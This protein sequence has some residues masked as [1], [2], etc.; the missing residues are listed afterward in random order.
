MRLKLFAPLAAVLL[1]A[2]CADDPKPAASTGGA[3]ATSAAPAPAASG[4]RPGS[5]ED[6]AVNAGDRVFF[7]FNQYSLKPDA[8]RTLQRQAAWMQR[9]ANV[10]LIIEGHAD[11][12]GTREYN[13]ALGNRRAVAVRDQLQSL[14]VAGTRLST[15]SYGKERPAVVGSNEAAWSQNRRAVS[16]V[17]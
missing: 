4:I 5:Q 2:A 9:N 7:D 3:G 12:R 8:V 14:G 17:Q 16:Q 1:L 11:E 13:I 15:I 6:L 10:R